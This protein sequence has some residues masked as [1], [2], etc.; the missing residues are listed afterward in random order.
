MINANGTRQ[1]TAISEAIT[2]NNMES[3]STPT[4]PPGSRNPIPSSVQ[5]DG[6]SLRSTPL[7][8]PGAKSEVTTL[9]RFSRDRPENTDG[10]MLPITSLIR[11]VSV[12]YTHLRAHE[13]D[14]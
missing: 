6:N 11:V 1:H 12:S 4:M 7:V 8:K 14:S 3:P 2:R 9:N 13:T 5:M 10:I